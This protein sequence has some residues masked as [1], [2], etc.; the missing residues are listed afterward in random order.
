MPE[1]CWNTLGR[2]GSGM[3]ATSIQVTTSEP[4]LATLREVLADAKAADLPGVS[5]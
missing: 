5:R 2:G 3:S 4:T 1:R